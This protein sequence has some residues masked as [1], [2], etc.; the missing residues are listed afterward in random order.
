MQRVIETALSQC[1]YLEKASA[2]QLDSYTANA[3]KGN[4][5]KYARDMDALRGWYNGHKQGYDWCAVFV[6]WCFVQ[7][8]GEA[9]AKKILP[10]TIYSAGC[11]SVVSAYRNAG[12][13]SSFPAVGD[14][15]I[16]MNGSGDPVHT[17]IVVAVSP[18]AVET[19]EGNTS[20]AA[21]VVANGGCVRRKIYSRNYRNIAG[22]GHPDWGQLPTQKKEDDDMLTLDQ[23]KGLYAQMRQELQDNDA[24][25]W[26]GEAREW[27][28]SKGIVQGAEDG[29]FNGMWQDVL[30]REQAV[31]L[32][33]RFARYIGAE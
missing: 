23:F 33:Y 7:A 14:Q 19:V 30:T 31:T 9:A 26:S 4:Y 32:L 25:T 29:N 22:Y 2:K 27:A 1:G 17:G 21:G 13:W 20:S 12:R 5:T 24:G 3:G 6:D 16:F 28:Q 18:S 8:Y 10:H 11:L 15:V